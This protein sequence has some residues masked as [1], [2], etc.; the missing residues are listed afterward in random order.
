MEKN[1][2]ISI[3]NLYKAYGKKEV[4]KGVNLQVGY[5]EMFGFIGANGAGKS[6]TVDCLIG[7]KSFTRGNI[8]VCGHDVVKEPIAAKRSFGYVASEPCCYGNMTG[9]GYFS[10]IAGVYGLDEKVYR[11]RLQG[12]LKQFRFDP[13]D[14]T[15]KICTYSHGMTQ[16]ICLIASLLH[17]PKVWI[18]DEPTVGLDAA[19]VD[20]LKTVMKERVNGG[21]T[22][23]F[24]SHNL[25]FVANLCDKVALIRDGQIAD[26]YNLKRESDA[27][28]KLEKNFFDLNGETDV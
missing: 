26:V 19:T 20:A 27:R 18:L 7:I 12:L 9:N 6:T 24:V 15:R 2:V 10:F 13:N 11:K 21:K 14:L 16:K 23:F 22:V 1:S 28:Q 5:G 25:E 4:L 17:D 3:E 8:S